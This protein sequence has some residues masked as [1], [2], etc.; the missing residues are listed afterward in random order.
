MDGKVDKHEFDLMFRRCVNDDTGLEP[1]GLFNLVQ[2]MM[3]DRH[4]HRKI[5]EEDTL[6]LIF[7]RQQTIPK[8][9]EVLRTIFG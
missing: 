6:E 5:T 8:L 7:V 2:F 4:R 3:Y 9:E 1:K